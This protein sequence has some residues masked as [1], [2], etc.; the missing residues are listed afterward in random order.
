MN[1]MT[2]TPSGEESAPTLHIDDG[3]AVIALRRPLRRNRLDDGDLGTLVAHAH[4]LAGLPASDVRVVRLEAEGP[5]FSAGYDL[6][7]LQA[8]PV[9]GP[10]R[11]DEAVRALA[12]LPQPTVCRLQGPV[13][14]GAGELALACDFRIGTPEVTLQV[15]AA[16][17]GL[18]YL[19]GGLERFAQA[20]GLP[21]TRRIFLAAEPLQA[22]ELLRIGYLD[23]CVEARQLDDEVHRWCRRLASAAPLAVRGMKAALGRWAA[24][25]AVATAEPSA[26]DEGAQGQAAVEAC[27]RSE[28]LQ[29]GLAAA[30]ARREPLFEA[31]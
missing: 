6:A 29:E 26:P 10:R 5:V 17:I 28:D 31:R 9:G 8:D 15:P 13:H 18:H 20:V 7:G 16:R 27:A 22:D 3:H 4:R 19:P 30:A 14:G 21:A 2:P 24:G 23:T 12:A 1:A 25:R 11:F